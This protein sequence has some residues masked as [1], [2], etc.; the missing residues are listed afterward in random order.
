MKI[1]EHCPQFSLNDQN[2]HLIH[3]SSFK[4]SFSVIY[5]YPKD[6]TPGCT[7]EACAFRDRY[8]EF[9]SLGCRVIGISSDDEAQHKKFTIK[10]NL[11]FILL[12]DSQGKVRKQFGVPSSLFGLLPGRV[13][14]IF[15]EQ[16][17]LLGTFNSQLNPLGHIDEALNLV[18]LSSKKNY[19]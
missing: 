12:A 16:S 1:G 15:D 4:G 19:E 6:D 5:F 9:L 3:S 18:K 14:Y 13:T 10:H 2:G 11:P 7:K 17:R 8:E